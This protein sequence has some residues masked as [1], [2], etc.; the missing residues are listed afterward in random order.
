M[1]SIFSLAN[2]CGMP[3]KIILCI[4]SESLSSLSRFNEAGRR[5]PQS[6]KTTIPCSGFLGH[7]WNMISQNFI[8][9]AKVYIILL[10]KT[11]KLK[12]PVCN[13]DHVY[14]RLH[15]PPTRVSPYSAATNWM[16][17][18][19]ILPAYRS[20]PSFHISTSQYLF[21]HSLQPR[22]LYFT[23]SLRRSFPTHQDSVLLRTALAAINVS[24]LVLACDTSMYSAGNVKGR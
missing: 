2:R 19:A 22:A 6:T 12:D 21:Y 1:L 8:R 11:S 15:T 3:C 23:T 16:V 5:F 17:R 24:V 4:C 18:S 7:D 20:S 9:I 13:R 10:R 14:L